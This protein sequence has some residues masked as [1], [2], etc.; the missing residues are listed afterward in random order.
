MNRQLRRALHAYLASQLTWNWNPLTWIGIAETDAKKIIRDI[1]SLWKW[2]IKETVLIGD[3]VW[4]DLYGVYKWGDGQLNGVWH[5]IYAVIW[6]AI[7]TALSS[8]GGSISGALKH[9]EHL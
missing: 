4:H 8:I 1:E 2:V 6:P 7:D 3:R 5:E 9:L